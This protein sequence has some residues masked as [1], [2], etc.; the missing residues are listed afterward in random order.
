M[1]ILKA[2]KD[3]QSGRTLPVPEH[4]RD[5]SYQGAKRLGR[6]EDYKYSHDFE[7]GYV[8]QT[9]LPEERRYYL[10]VD[11]GFEKVIRERLEEWRR[12]A[13]HGAGDPGEA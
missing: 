4:L 11:R 5:A 3:V 6:G 9:Y 7:G 8:Q 13:S 1:A 2:S 12:K 10:P